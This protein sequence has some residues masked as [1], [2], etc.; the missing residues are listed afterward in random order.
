MGNVF[1]SVST[2]LDGFLA[3]PHRGPQRPMGEGGPAIHKW[4]FEQVA[5][6]RHLGISERGATG[7]DND[8]LEAVIART[9]STIIG[10]RMFDEGEVA[11]PEVAPFRT[12]VFVLTHTPR[13]PWVRPGGTTFHFVTDGIASALRHAR[14]AAGSRDVRIGG[15]AHTIVQF[16]NAGLVDELHL[17]IAPI[18]FGEGLRLLEGID[19]AKVRLDIVDAT[20]STHV[21][22]LRYRVRRP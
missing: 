16:L 17:G 8:V 1:V 4:A 21:T 3:G 10:K 12:P 15:G 11:W 13:E 5:M 7:P 6:Q 22:H 19:R 14:E 9:G 2:T 20:P 18:V